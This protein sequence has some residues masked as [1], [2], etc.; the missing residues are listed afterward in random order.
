M[1]FGMFC[2]SISKRTN[3]QP[4]FISLE[5]LCGCGGMA[6]ALVLGA[7]SN[8]SKGSSPFARTKEKACRNA[9]FSFVY[10]ALQAVLTAL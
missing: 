10:A 3:S 6:D 2:D 5:L 8:R 7:S 1:K 4:K 9:G